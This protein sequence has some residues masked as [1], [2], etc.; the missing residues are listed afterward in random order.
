MHE[1]LFN[2]FDAVPAAACASVHCT[3]P[4]V[5]GLV[6][7]A[8]PAGAAITVE[9]VRATRA[10]AVATS[11]PTRG[12]CSSFLRGVFILSKRWACS[13]LVFVATAVF[14]RAFVPTLTEGRMQQKVH[15]VNGS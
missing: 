1:M 9:A 7:F 15:K 2:W 10:P 13:L 14:L 12:M 3:A 4:T 11:S 8:A 6:G 5:G